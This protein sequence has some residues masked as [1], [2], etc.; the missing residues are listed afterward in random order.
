MNKRF[1]L[2]LLA[3][4]FSFSAFAAP[5][6]DY[7]EKKDDNDMDALRRWLNDK[8][9]ITVKELGGD[10]SLSGDVRTELQAT[11]EELETIN[12]ELRQRTLDLNEVNS[13]LESILVSLGAGVVVL[14]EE[15]RVRAWNEQAAEL[16]GLRPD[17]VQGQHFANLDIGLATDRLLPLVPPGYFVVSSCTCGDRAPPRH[18]FSVSSA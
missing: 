12:E 11:N 3:A 15:L 18:P 17:E 14:D 6:V 9:L 1:S 2:A 7:A 5:D 10:L 16:W 4:A 13:F 8:R